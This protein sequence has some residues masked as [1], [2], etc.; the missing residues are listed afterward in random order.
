MF[1][2]QESVLALGTRV[3]RIPWA[4]L[5]RKRGALLQIHRA[6]LR[7]GMRVSSSTRA[8]RAKWPAFL[9]KCRALLQIHRV[10]FMKKKNLFE[11]FAHET[12]T[13]SGR[14]LH[15]LNEFFDEYFECRVW[16]KKILFIFMTIYGMNMYKSININVYAYMYAYIYMCV[17]ASLNRFVWFLFETAFDQQFECHIWHK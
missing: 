10:L 2:G 4:A 14:L 8:A 6:L 12:Y 11:L 5:L 15:F 13:Q 3:T 16:H 17:Y 7:K 9:Q 1:C